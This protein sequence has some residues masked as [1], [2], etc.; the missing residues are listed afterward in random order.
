VLKELYTAAMGM[1]PQQ[2][3]LEVISNNMANAST[4]GFKRQS[5]FERNLIDARAN[6]NN[7]KGDAEQNDPPIGSYTDFK[8]GDTQETNNRL[9]LFIANPEAFFVLRDEEGKEFLTRAGNFTIA[10]DGSLRSASSKLVMGQ[11]G[12]I[13]FNAEFFTSPD[14]TGQGNLL[15]IRISENGEIFANDFNVGEFKLVVPEDMQTLQRI[16]GSDFIATNITNMRE[17]ELDQID[18]RQGYLEGSNVDIVSEMVQ[19]IELQKSFEAGQKVITTNDGTLDRSIGI[20]RY[21]T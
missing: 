8:M 17:L 9:D 11:N 12:P 7:V 2:T 15:N 13:D 14:K 5:V 6:F 19:M 16:S 3:R 20:G 10:E 1:M 4:S 18:V 21:F